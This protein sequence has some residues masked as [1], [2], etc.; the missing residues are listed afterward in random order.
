MDS[1][2]HSGG[3]K[4]RKFTSS[5]FSDM[6]FCWFPS[7][8]RTANE[9]HLGLGLLVRNI[10]CYNIHILSDMSAYACMFFLSVSVHVR[11]HGSKCLC[12][13][14]HILNRS[15][16]GLKQTGCRLVKLF[17]EINHTYIQSTLMQADWDKNKEAGTKIETHIKDEADRQRQSDV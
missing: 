17:K 5:I 16:S 8:F 4:Y 6:N 2:S 12:V 10:C 11:M 1:L 7:S 13:S 9:I 15:R 14:S 3:S